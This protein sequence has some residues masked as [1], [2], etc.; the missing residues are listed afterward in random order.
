MIINNPLPS[1]HTVLDYDFTYTNGLG[2]TI[3]VDE[4]AGD[5]VDWHTSPLTVIFR[6]ASKPSPINPKQTI[7]S[8]EMTIFLAHILVVRKS[9]RLITPPTTEQ[10]EEL[11][12]L[13]NAASQLVH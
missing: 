1:P 10:K 5:T 3:T 9:T 8:E 7:P 13:I 12:H 2:Q 6:M 11:H 4:A